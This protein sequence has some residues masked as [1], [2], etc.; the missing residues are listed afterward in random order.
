MTVT[1]IET[2]RT[3]SPEALKKVLI[4]GDLAKLTAEQRADY[5]AAL[6]ESLGLNP[7]S[8]PFEFLML[9]GKLRC[10]ATRDCTDQL[11]KL[12]GVS[13]AITGRE[14]SNDCYIVTAQAEDARGRRDESIGVVVVQGLT[15]VERANA[16]MTCETKAKRRVT[17]SV[18]G[19][20]VLDELELETVVPRAPR[21]EFAPPKGVATAAA[22]SGASMSSSSMSEAHATNGTPATSAMGVARPGKRGPT[23]AADVKYCGTPATL[24]QLAE[25][26]RLRFEIGGKWITGDDDARTDWRKMLQVYRGSQGE[27]CQAVEKLCETQAAHLISRG[28]GILAKRAEHPLEPIDLGEV[29]EPDSEGPTAAELEELNAAM[30]RDGT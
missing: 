30:G 20:G 12:Y 11:R 6:C 10:Y 18:C 26:Q 13:I 27:R 8:R 28:M 22:V 15:G 1:P 17:L 16:L 23:G 21:E 4:H 25:I 14:L 24:T 19:L 5:M 29:R 2:A 3:L 9:D 7:L